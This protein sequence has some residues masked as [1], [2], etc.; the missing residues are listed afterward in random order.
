M[1]WTGAGL[2]AVCCC[3][4]ESCWLRCKLHVH[5]TSTSEYLI[6]TN[7]QG[8][9]RVVVINEPRSG[10][11]SVKLCTVPRRHMA[12]ARRD[13]V[14]SPHDSIGLVQQSKP[15]QLVTLHCESQP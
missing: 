14:V 10:R 11:P 3:V 7:K 1:Y 12:R 6:L 13:T 5:C 15:N 9:H 2:D 8:T 4:V